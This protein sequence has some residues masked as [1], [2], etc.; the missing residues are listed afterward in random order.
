VGQNITPQSLGL[1]RRLGARYAAIRSLWEAKRTSQVAPE[2]TRLTQTGSRCGGQ[3][4]L[5]KTAVRLPDHLVAT[6]EQREHVVGGGS[7]NAAAPS[8][9]L[10]VAL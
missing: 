8:H 10:T 2:M 3:F 7:D 4:A 6:A 1:A 5:H 9:Y